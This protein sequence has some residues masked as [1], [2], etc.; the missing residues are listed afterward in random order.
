MDDF[1]MI[2]GLC[3]LAL[4]NSETLALWRSG[5]LALW[6]SFWLMGLGYGWMM[7]GTYITHHTYY[8]TLFRI[9]S[10]R[11]DPP[12]SSYEYQPTDRSIDRSTF[13]GW[14]GF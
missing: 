4:W 9:G 12:G 5:A 7:D 6:H 2:S 1:W 10:I 13:L 11:L 8:S 14:A 3:D